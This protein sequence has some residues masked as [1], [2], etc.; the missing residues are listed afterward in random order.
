MTGDPPPAFRRTD[1]GTPFSVGPRRHGIGVEGQGEAR[2]PLDEVISLA[3]AARLSGL[4]PHTLTLQAEK[5]KLRARK[6][7]H[8]WITTEHWLDV[9]LATH[10]RHR[11]PCA[12]V[13]AG[14]PAEV[15][16]HPRE[17]RGQ[18]D[19]TVPRPLAGHG[20][21]KGG[22]MMRTQVAIV[23]AGPA[24]LVLSH[25]LARQGVESIVLESRSRD[26]VEKR[27]RAGV[28]EQGTVDLLCA[29]GVGDR[30]RREGL[31]HHGIELRF[32]GQG[33]RVP[34][35]DL[36]GGRAITVYGQQEVVKDLIRARLDAGGQVLFEAEALGVDDLTSE[37]PRVRYRHASRELTLAADVVAGCDGFRGVS[38]RAI[39]DAALTRYEKEYPFAWLGI[40]AATPPA[41][42]E[43]IYA[44]HD[45]GFALHS[46]RTPEISRLYVQCRPDERLED[47]P[48]ERV[49]QEL[50]LRLASRDGRTVNP[51]PV[52][53]KGITTMRSFVVEPMQYGRLFLAGDAAHI[54][55]PTG[56]KGMNLAIA[57]VRVL[58]EALTGWF[59]SGRTDLLEAYS[60]TCLR[61]VWRA[62]H[63]SW[64]MTTML[65]RLPD[66]D[67]G[68]QQRLQ[69]SQLR[70]LVGSRAAAATLAENYVGLDSA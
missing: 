22:A 29:S 39:P 14:V 67:G 57:D 50:G 3:E 37:S 2:D 65:H 33:H 53:E 32:D 40:L 51:G 43:L 12:G 35:S 46:M 21:R 69:L 59:R 19:A 4:A 44:Y 41:S 27:V 49:W 15:P 10:S 63:F 25:L 61:R 20:G 24:G 62:E 34:L 17:G 52:L 9:Y 58:A 11:R 18:A 56:A 68:F 7:G 70:Y 55:P 31:V 66:D 30:L 45:R 1:H 23:G 38:R 48:D 6:V 36:T 13:P 8:T 64:W 47:W 16:E 42:E 60:E 28:L 26:Y 5:G 54:V